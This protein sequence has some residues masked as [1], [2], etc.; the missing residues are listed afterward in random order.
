MKT[1]IILIV[2]VYVNM[3]ACVCKVNIDKQDFYTTK[4]II[5]ARIGAS[6]NTY[7]LSIASSEEAPEY[8][9]Y[10]SDFYGQTKKFTFSTTGSHFIEAIANCSDGTAARDTKN[11]EIV[12]GPAN[13]I[14]LHS[15]NKK[16]KEVGIYYDIHGRRVKNPKKMGLYIFKTKTSV[17]KIF[18]H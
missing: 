10:T 6:S 12:D 17:R 9:R 11:I 2:C 5:T 16:V 7:Q 15:S 8:F 3:Y 13:I 4:S 14:Q 1:L 18:V